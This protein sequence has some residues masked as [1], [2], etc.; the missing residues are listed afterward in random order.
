VV[1]FAIVL[2]VGSLLILSRRAEFSI[3]EALIELFIFGIASHCWL[4]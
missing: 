3:N 1:V 4:G 2:Y